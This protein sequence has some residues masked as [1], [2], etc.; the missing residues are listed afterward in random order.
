[1]SRRS[2]TSTSAPPTLCPETWYSSSTPAATF[3]DR[4]VAHLEFGTR[5]QMRQHLPRRYGGEIGHA[6]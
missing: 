1:M 6:V 4:I 2:E 3:S 5:A